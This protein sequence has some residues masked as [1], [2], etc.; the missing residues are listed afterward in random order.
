MRKSFISNV[1]GRQI[2]ILED[3]KNISHWF[4]F[5]IIS[6]LFYGILFAFNLLHNV[7]SQH[8]L[9]VY[10]N[11]SLHKEMR[12]LIA[13]YYHAHIA[14]V[15]LLAT[16]PIILLLVRGRKHLRLKLLENQHLLETIQSMMQLKDASRRHLNAF[17]THILE[18]QTSML[19]EAKACTDM[20][21]EVISG[22]STLPLTSEEWIQMGLNTRQVL[23]NIPTATMFDPV[24]ETIS[25]LCVLNEVQECLAVEILRKN[26]D[27]NIHSYAPPWLQS[28]PVLLKFLLLNL[29]NKCLSKLPEHSIL[30]I[31]ICGNRNYLKICI[32]R[33]DDRG[34]TSAT[35]GNNG[36]DIAGVKLTHS[37]IEKVARNLGATCSHNQ[38]E[39]NQTVI[40]LPRFSTI[41]STT[42][43]DNVV[44][45]DDYQSE[46]KRHPVAQ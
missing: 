39:D 3:N 16:L 10:E 20:I 13:T 42:L 24:R 30:T 6:V 1:F 7:K 35:P 4:I 28:D 38:K 27:V 37:Q 21:N 26:L 45:L 25:I 12:E 46:S 14:A 31:K 9:W 8:I 32:H 17:H 15:L 40:E 33:T 5:I 23:E 29:F 2:F 11:L 44:F 36:I 41:E 18:R 43:P 34:K 19:K 22:N